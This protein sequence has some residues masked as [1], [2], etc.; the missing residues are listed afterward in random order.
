MRTPAPAAHQGRWAASRRIPADIA[1]D[2]RTML[3]LTVSESRLLRDAVVAVLQDPVFEHLDKQAEDAVWR[4]AARASLVAKGDLV[5]DFVAEH[6]QS[7]VRLTCYIPIECLKVVEHRRLAQLS[8]LPVDDAD[9][10]S[11]GLDLT[12]PI[13]SVAAVPVEGTHYGW[14]SDRAKA[15]VDH[16]LRVV[17]IALRAD[18]FVQDRQLRFR[19]GTGYSFG[20]G[21]TGWTLTDDASWELTVDDDLEQLAGADPL[22]TLAGPADTDIARKGA[23][24]LRWLERSWLVSDQLESL[25]F[26]FFAL[27]ALLGDQSEKLKARGL[28]FR[29][30]MLSVATRGSFADPN[31]TYFLYDRVRS[32]AVRGGQPPEV[33]TRTASQFKYD[34]R[35]ALVEYLEYARDQGLARRGKLLQSLDSHAERPA[36]VNWLRE[37]GGPAW[38]DF[39]RP[40]G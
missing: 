33:D 10:Q 31:T 12:H 8:L 17:R 16:Q 36:L 3:Y 28:A 26:S 32:A 1:L 2:D 18:Q 23:L 30:A 40:G 6:A 34:A 25:L 9:V 11:L 24:A 15:E 19:R 35:R 27:E 5:D 29:R 7:V 13:G 38:D 20:G 4:L 37:H 39:E 21:L 14:M 22:A